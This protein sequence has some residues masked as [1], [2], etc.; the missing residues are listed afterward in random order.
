MFV[1]VMLTV[2]CSDRLSAEERQG[3]WLR[4]DAGNAGAVT[5]LGLAASNKPRGIGAR[6]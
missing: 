6:A 1:L 2:Y 3:L 4:L 5:A